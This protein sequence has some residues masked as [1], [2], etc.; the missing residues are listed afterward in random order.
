MYCCAT[1]KKA[2]ARE[3]RFSCFM[4]PGWECEES[5]KQRVEKMRVAGVAQK[6]STDADLQELEVVGDP[7]EDFNSGDEGD[8][9]SLDG[10]ATPPGATPPAE[11]AEQAAEQ[12]EAE[13]AP[14]TGHSAEE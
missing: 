7:F 14:Q 6:P 8:A 13:T 4:H 1:C 10:E 2:D 5:T 12:A 9:L 11:T 3:H